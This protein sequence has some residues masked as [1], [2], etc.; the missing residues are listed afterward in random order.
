MWSEL[1]TG[2]MLSGVDV[3]L[4]QG[5]YIIPSRIALGLTQPTGEARIVCL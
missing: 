3:L 1:N 4:F 5:A 2:A